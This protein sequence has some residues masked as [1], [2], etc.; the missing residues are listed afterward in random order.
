[1]VMVYMI[2][3]MWN[4]QKN[5]LLLRVLMKLDICLRSMK[6]V[7]ILFTD[8]KKLL[9][10]NIAIRITKYN[11]DINEF[12]EK[13]SAFQEETSILQDPMEEE[14]DD[15]ANSLDKKDEEQSEEQNEEERR[16]TLQLIHCLISLRSYRRMNAM[17]IAMIP[18]IRL[19]YPFL[20]KLMLAMLVAMIPI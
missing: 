6:I 5:L 16:V 19:K 4:E 10:L 17:I 8:L 7:M 11:A 20:M 9:Y 15:T 3:M 18:W 13:V 2:T 14:I 12:I 1:M